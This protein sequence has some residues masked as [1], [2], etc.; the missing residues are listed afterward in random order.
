[1]IRLETKNYNTTITEKKQ[2]I[3]IVNVSLVKKYYL[4]ILFKANSRSRKK[5]VEALLFLNP[6]QQLK[7]IEGIFPWNFLNIETKDEIDTIEMD[8]TINH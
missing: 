7:S 2:K 4:L 8:R 3:T 1:M 6:K 5:Q